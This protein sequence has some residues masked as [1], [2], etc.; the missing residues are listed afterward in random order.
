MHEGEKEMPSPLLCCIQKELPAARGH[1]MNHGE[2]KKMKL[3]VVRHGETT[4]NARK[5]IQGT[6]DIPLDEKGIALA[7]VTGEALK[8]IP[9]DFAISSPLK[10]AL[11][12]ARYVLGHRQVPVYTDQRI[13]EI[14]FGAMEGTSLL[15]GSAG[16]FEENFR[17]F[18]QEPEKY[19][20]PKGGESLE[21]V[22]RRTGEFLTEVIGKKEW[23]D[24]TILIASHGCAVRAMLQRFYQDDL[25]F[26][27]G[28][29]PPNC[30]VNLIE[31]KDGQAV[32]TAQDQ[33]YY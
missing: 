30:S 24:A 27:H 3:Y 29:V 22:C 9:F 13:R 25:G 28:K 12:T 8:E 18:F 26:W 7:K 14:C 19:Q 23:E 16:E 1:K 4:W 20:P 32:L 17:L 6:A 33:I 15:D 31:V 10:R 11:D 5:K 2:Y 21:E